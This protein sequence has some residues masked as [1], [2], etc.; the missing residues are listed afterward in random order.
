MHG[1]V[2]GSGRTSAAP[3]QETAAFQKRTYLVSHGSAGRR[4]A[5]VARH[6]FRHKTRKEPFSTQLMLIAAGQIGAGVTLLLF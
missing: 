4:G 5:F 6:L 2:C 3:L 1:P